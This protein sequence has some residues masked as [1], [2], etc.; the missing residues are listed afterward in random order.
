MVMRVMTPAWLRNS[1]RKRTPTMMAPPAL[2]V[3]HRD[4]SLMNSD[5]LKSPFCAHTPLLTEM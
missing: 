5:I 1:C 2:T 4:A 3:S